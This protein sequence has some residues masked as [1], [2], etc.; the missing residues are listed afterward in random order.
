M[1]KAPTLALSRGEMVGKGALVSLS[2]SRQSA[3]GMVAVTRGTL[4]TTRVVCPLPVRS[5]ARVTWLSVSE[6]LAFWYSFSSCSRLE[7]TAHEIGV[8]YPFSG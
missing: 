7:P 8:Y 2:A 5:S 6:G 3:R 4:P 1:G